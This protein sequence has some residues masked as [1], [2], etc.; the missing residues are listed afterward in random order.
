MTTDFAGHEIPRR[1]APIAARPAHRDVARY[2]VPLG[3]A[4][5]VAIFLTSA[6]EHFARGTIEHAA[7]QGVPLASL[8]VPF[9][10]VLALLG[11]LSVLLGYHARI[12][13]LFLV[14]F[15]VPVTLMMHRFWGVPDPSA[16]QLQEIMFMKNVSMLGG[17]LLIAYFGAG[18]VSI[19]ARNE[20]A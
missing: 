5:F 8:A 2:L 11:G 3:R 14:A 18:P 19:D 20:N 15:L 10:G 1:N 17:A 7:A 4:L 9:S 13:A 16:A 6:P 12:G